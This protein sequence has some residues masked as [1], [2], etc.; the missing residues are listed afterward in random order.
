MKSTKK[1]LHSVHKTIISHSN[2][3]KYH[4]EQ[5]IHNIM[6]FYK[7]HIH[8][9]SLSSQFHNSFKK[10]CRYP[11]N[12]DSCIIDPIIIFR[13]IVINIKS[14]GCLIRYNIR[15]LPRIYLHHD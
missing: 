3:H 1:V 13:K 14:K 5:Q 4:Q 6:N 2:C 15:I 12:I 8:K 10:R 11:I 9:N 7:Y